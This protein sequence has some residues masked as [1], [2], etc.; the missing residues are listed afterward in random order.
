[1]CHG[2]D[3]GIGNPRC[4]HN[5]V[6]RGIRKSENS[7]QPKSSYTHTMFVT[8]SIDFVDGTCVVRLVGDGGREMSCERKY[9][10]LVV[11]RK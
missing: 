6:N 8:G 7:H 9:G 5:T 4:H 2:G 3:S 1:M 11:R 10:S